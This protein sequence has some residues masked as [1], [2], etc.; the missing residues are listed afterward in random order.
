M[1]S[2]I[3]LIG[4]IIL[5][6]YNFQKSRTER[7]LEKI[8]LSYIYAP[9]EYTADLLTKEKRPFPDQSHQ[10]HGEHFLN[11]RDYGAKGDGKTDDTTAFNAA[12]TAAI[13]QRKSLYIPE[14][15][16]Y[17]R[18]SSPLAWHFNGAPDNQ[19]IVIFGA[20]PRN[21]VLDFQTDYVAGPALKITGTTSQFY[22][23]FSGFSVQCNTNAACVQVGSI[24]NHDV[25]NE[26]VFDYLYISNFSTGANAIGL[27]LM[28]VANS[29]FDNFTLN[30]AAPGTGTAGIRLNT[31]QFSKFFGSIGNCRTAMLL[32]DDITNGYSMGNV[33]L[34]MD[35]EVSTIGIAIKSSKATRNTWIGGHSADVVHVIDATAGNNNLFINGNFAPLNTIFAGDGQ[36]STGVRLL[37][38]NY[39]TQRTP[40]IP[41][42]AILVDGFY[43]PSVINK[44]GQDAMIY[45]FGGDVSSVAVNNA[46]VAMSSAATIKLRVGESIAISYRTA[47]SWTWRPD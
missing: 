24:D 46:V 45:I 39:G 14:S 25:F 22:N 1:L 42:S 40:S 28:A 19:G 43:T 34:A 18:L 21:T 5:L 31:V 37:G 3:I 7:F 10:I 33:F 20:S 2:N 27:D 13:N 29:N 4:M 15:A 17:Y 35:F 47:P 26:A 23:K 12:F 44:S 30:C 11:V 38:G 36:N 9:I 41:A 6:S 16:A 32:T 8:H